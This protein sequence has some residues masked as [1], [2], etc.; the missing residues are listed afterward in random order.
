MVKQKIK[1][2]VKK[3]MVNGGEYSDHWIIDNVQY[4]GKNHTASML[5]EYYFDHFQ[6]YKNQ[7]K[8][9]EY[10]TGANKYG[11]W[12]VSDLPLIYSTFRALSN[13]GGNK[14]REVRDFVLHTLLG[15]DIMTLTRIKPDTDEYEVTHNIDT[16][17]QYVKMTD[18]RATKGSKQYITPEAFS[19]FIQKQ[20]DDRRGKLGEDAFNRE[21]NYDFI[22]KAIVSKFSR[23][24]K[25]CLSSK[26][27]EALFGT[28]DADEINSVFRWF[29]GKDLSFF[30]TGDNKGKLNGP[31]ML[32]LN[33]K[34]IQGPTISCHYNSFPGFG[35]YDYKNESWKRSIERGGSIR[36]CAYTKGSKEERL[37]KEFQD[38]RKTKQI[39]VGMFAVPGWGGSKLSF[40]TIGDEEK[41]N[42]KKKEWNSTSEDDV[43]RF[44]AILPHIIRGTVK[45]DIKFLD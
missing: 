40:K 22:D 29:T 39:Y 5:G 27:L 21:D 13:N 2:T 31:V 1:G 10:T 7:K 23:S 30:A 11:F 45:D 41:Y 12:S 36:L 28:P 24:I 4:G 32:N 6:N 25:Q 34:G 35:D 37:F 14:A 17:N 8:F 42:S 19:K 16:P 33:K 44:M 20:Y 38:R 3:V 18:F 15:E 26:N 43:N 9:S